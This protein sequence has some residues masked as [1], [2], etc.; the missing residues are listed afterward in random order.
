MEAAIFLGISAN[1]SSS[2]NWKWLPT[3]E[4]AI[5]EEPNFKMLFC[6]RGM[7]LNVTQTALYSSS[8]D[9]PAFS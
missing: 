1:Q 9:V 8:L 2:F 3:L 5:L 7:Q 6:H 4:V